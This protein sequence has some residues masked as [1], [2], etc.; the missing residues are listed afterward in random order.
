[1]DGISYKN[2][3]EYRAG[4]KKDPSLM[5]YYTFEDKAVA[6]MASVA[7]NSGKKDAGNYDGKVKN[8]VWTEGR[9]KEKKAMSFDDNWLEAIPYNIENKAFTCEMWIRKNGSGSQKGNNDYKNGTIIGVSG[10]STGWRITTTC[11]IPN[12]VIHFA[13]G[14]PTSKPQVNSKP[15]SDGEWH[16]LTAVWDGK[17]LSLYID[18]DL[19]AERDYSEDYTPVPASADAK[20]EW[21]RIGYAD[22][23]VGSVKMD[24]DEVAIYNRALSADEIKKHRFMTIK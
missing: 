22:L 19:S 2:W 3:L 7:N 18:G 12:G 1:M 24:V 21:L 9:W 23:G 16:L 5:V 15:V 6:G 11:E 4:L 17:K 8:P 13:L 14:G 10:W 20:H